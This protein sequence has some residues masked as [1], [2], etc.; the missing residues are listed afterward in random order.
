MKHIVL[1]TAYN[2]L[3]NLLRQLLVYDQDKDFRVYIHWDKRVATQKIMDV[4]SAH[5]SVE[6]VCSKYNIY[7]G[8]RNLLKSMLFLCQCALDDLYK[9]G[10]KH[11]FFHL[12]S[13]TDVL[14]KTTKDIKKIFKNSVYEGFIEYFPLPTNKWSEGGMNRLIWYH[15][16]DRWNIHD[17]REYQVYQRYLQLQMRKGI[18]RKLPKIKLYGGSCWWSLSQTLVTYWVKNFNQD[19]FFERLNDTYCPEEVHIHTILLNSPY[20]DRICNTSLRYICWDYGTRG[21]PALLENFDL[22]YIHQSEC[23]WGRKMP[24]D[25]KSTLHEYFKWFYTLPIYPIKR[26]RSINLIGLTH[27]LL[28]HIDKCPI[29]G[30]MD[31]KMGAVVYLCCYAK[32]MSDDSI[33]S[34]V[35]SLLNEIINTVF[36]NQSSDFYNGIIGIAYA[37]A[38]LDKNRLI[39]AQ[40]KYRIFLKKLDRKILQ[41]DKIEAFCNSLKHPLWQEYYQLHLYINLR[42]LYCP[43]ILNQSDISRIVSLL[44]KAG[45]SSCKVSI[46]IAGLSGYGF[47]ELHRLFPNA[48][49]KLFDRPL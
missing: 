39:K 13:G 26:N 16:L 6:R 14:L 25:K 37:L 21:T 35:H 1:I 33:L 4:I 7:W 38:W 45:K 11:S 3:D 20:R 5:P 40:P 32:V 10:E 19:N 48:L 44:N 42:Q 17:D 23:I 47:K 46:G 43:N 27:Y 49:P 22:P 41:S 8:G 12:I 30:L 2:Q 9:E 29:L 15:P 18:A 36:E 28:E 24:R 34:K 31:G